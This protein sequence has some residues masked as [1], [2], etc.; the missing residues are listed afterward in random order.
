MPSSFRPLAAVAAVGAA[1]MVL[2]ACSGSIAQDDLE[3]R[4]A[5]ELVTALGTYPHV[6]CEGDLAGEVD[7]TTSCTATHPQTGE[8]IHFDATVTAVDGDT[9]NYR[10]EPTY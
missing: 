3:A 10:I 1:V 6:S 4:I 9:V 2:G 8:F 7:A 5:S